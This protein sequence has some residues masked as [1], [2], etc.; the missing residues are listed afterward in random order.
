MT[1]KILSQDFLKTHLI[2]D[3]LLKDFINRR[4]FEVAVK[5]IPRCIADLQVQI[6]NLEHLKKLLESDVHHKAQTSDDCNATLN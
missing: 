5:E 2:S 3:S 1:D 6:S 4:L